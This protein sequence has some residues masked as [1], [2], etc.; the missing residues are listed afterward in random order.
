MPAPRRPPLIRLHRG[1]L[2][3][4][5]YP[6]TTGTSRIEKMKFPNDPNQALGE[7]IYLGT[8]YPWTHCYIERGR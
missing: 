8:G 2:N 6:Y 3:H 5:L 7:F 4:L 1:A